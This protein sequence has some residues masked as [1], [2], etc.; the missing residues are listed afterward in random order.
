MSF[1]VQDV[2]EE[3][4]DYSEDKEDIEGNVP[5][6]REGLAIAVLL[7]DKSDP[8]VPEFDQV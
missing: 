3:L 5:E 8:P 7:E 6:E 1:S 4:V 2:E